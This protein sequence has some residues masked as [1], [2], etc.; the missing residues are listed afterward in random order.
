MACLPSASRLAARPLS[1]LPRVSQVYGFQCSCPR[2][3][4]EASPAWQ[5]ATEAA[6]GEGDGG[7]SGSWETDSTLDDAGVSS[8]EGQAAQQPHPMT[9][10]EEATV[11]GLPPADGGEQ[12][13]AGAWHCQA[14]G[15]QSP[16]QGDVAAAGEE[17]LE[18]TYLQLYLLK[19]M[20]PRRHCFGTMAP[21]AASSTVCE[22]NVCGRRRSEAEFLAELDG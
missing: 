15:R 1:T 10:H 3:R 11:G 20:C 22:C 6:A 9:V 13:A 8:D 5:E 4:T 16:G 19:Y 18:P 7:G 21:T 17:A 12:Q 2:C 14:A